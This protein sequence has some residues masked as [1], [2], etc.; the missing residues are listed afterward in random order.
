MRLYIVAYDIADQKRLARVRKAAYAYAFGG[1][2][3]AIESYLD[4]K[5]LR[6]LI[7][8]LHPLIDPKKDRINIIEI[9]E[10]AILLGK[11]SRLPF[12]KGAIIL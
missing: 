11:A 10:N 4:N 9:H 8:R 1:Q 12:D 6:E 2:K 7:Y 5:G 3:S